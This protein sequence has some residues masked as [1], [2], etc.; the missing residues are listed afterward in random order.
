MS[1]MHDQQLS[2]VLLNY[3]RIELARKAV[4]NIL[5]DV[6]YSN[7]ELI[8]VD[9]HSTDGTLEF[10][11]SIKDPRIK[12]VANKENLFFGGGLNCGL[13]ICSGKYV[14]L[15]QN[16]MTFQPAS[17][18]NLIELF[19]LLPN[20]GCVGIGGGFINRE[21]VITEISDWWQNP[22]R[23]F[24]YI[25]VDFLSGCCMLFE[26]KVFEAHG[27]KFDTKYRLYW[28]DVDI[29]HQIRKNGYELYMINNKLIG[30][31][32]LRSGTITPLLGVVQRE[33]I[34]EES[35][36]YYKQKWAGF[37]KN[38]DAM[39]K[40]IQ[41]R[42]FFESLRFKL[43]SYVG[44]AE[45]IEAHKNDAGDIAHVE[46][47]EF[48]GEFEKAV[49]GYRN[50]IKKNP[51]NFM[52]YRNLFRIAARRN[53]LKDSEEIISEFRIYLKKKPPVSLRRQLY[54]YVQ[55]ALLKIARDYA[56]NKD[57]RSAYHYYDELQKF[58]ET[59]Q[60]IALC[61]IEKAKIKYLEGNFSEA[62]QEMKMWLKKNEF[63]E[64]ELM[65]FTAAHFYLGEIAY[66]RSDMSVAIYRY[67][68]TLIIDPNHKRA[69]KRLKVLNAIG[70]LN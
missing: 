51:D 47:L 20:V 19:K 7:F 27:I 21:G 55:S 50:I 18:K 29:C 40:G 67:N 14:L 17:L 11:K 62:E 31:H 16:D 3:N 46:F 10:I 43:E 4:N 13:E 37:Y 8:I 52:A 63:M 25:P 60:T 68:M 59:A 36:S 34:R 45:E 1:T 33:K 12:L 24:D 53:D 38:P 28:E 57:Y 6:N 44:V 15:T 23:Q 9:N 49:Q 66:Q 58:A 2:I 56:D 70:G 32:H 22:L 41:Y 26:R 35:E 39:V 42:F 69:K 30:I 48:Q 61:E 64:L 54:F 65:M 5:N